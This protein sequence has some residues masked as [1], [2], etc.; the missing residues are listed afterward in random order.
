MNFEQL[1]S[2]YYDELNDNDKHII[3]FIEN[4]KNCFNYTIDEFSKK[5][6]VSKTSL[7]RFSKKIGLPGFGELKAL[8]KW[9]EYREN[10]DDSSLI[11]L[12][13]SNY[14]KMIDDISKKDFSNIFEHLDN[15]KRIVVYGSGYGQARVASEFKRIF[16]P[17]GKTI[18]C[19]NGYDMIDSLKG[20]V[21]DEDYVVIIS[22][23]GQ[24]EQV[25]EFVKYLKLMNIKSLSITRMMTNPVA[26][27]CDDSLY[28]NSIP[29][30]S[31]Y[32][33]EYEIA[34]PYFMLIEM[35][36]IYYQKHLEEL[37]T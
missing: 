23:S 7:V 37:R 24:K 34:T 36:Y 21:S 29:I 28:I 18:I 22:L 20:V 9:N 25:V 16:L 15:C 31:R 27:I 10:D 3:R 35:M 2:N 14:Y 33:I 11:E 19:M 6:L 5:C 8:L 1:I 4:N 30:P 26:S 17:T 12:V 32:K 13:E